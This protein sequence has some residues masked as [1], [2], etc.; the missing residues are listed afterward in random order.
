MKIKTDIRRERH[1]HTHTHVY[2]RE[3]ILEKTKK[4]NLHIA[5]LQIRFNKMV[6]L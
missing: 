3:D 4:T 6:T 5:F 1:L 2:N